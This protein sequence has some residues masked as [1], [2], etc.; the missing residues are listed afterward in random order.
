M[1]PVPLSQSSYVKT[2]VKWTNEARK[3]FERIQ[4]DKK[5]AQREYYDINSRDLYVH[6]GNEFMF[7]FLL[8]VQQKN[9]PLPVLSEDII[10]LSLLL[11]MFMDARICYT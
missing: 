1:P 2:L 5:S 6:D 11:V 7:A 4:A 9:E 8:R 10:D 3:S